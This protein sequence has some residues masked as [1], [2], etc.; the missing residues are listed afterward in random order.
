MVAGGVSTIV[1][2]A[3]AAV[4]VSI[5]VFPLL[6]T[7]SAPVAAAGPPSTGTTEYV[8]LRTKGSNKL[9]L[10]AKNGNDEPDEKSVDMA[11]S[12]G[13]DVSSRI[14]NLGMKTWSQD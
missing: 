14:M 4:T 8:A 3:G 5:I 1:F 6:P 10:R 2:V 12:A 11:K 9:T 13:I 7:P